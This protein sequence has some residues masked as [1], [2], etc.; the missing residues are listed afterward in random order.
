[1]KKALPYFIIIAIISL[2]SCSQKEEGLTADEARN[3]AKE[4]YIYG[5]PM[6]VNYKTMYMYAIDENSPE[7]KGKFNQISCVAR[8]FTPED[9]AVVTPNSDTPYCMFWVDLR[10]GPQV[11]TLP[12]IEPDRYYSFQLVDLYT[13]N[14]A[15]L[16]TLS[17]GNSGG[18]Y[19]VAP[20][21]WDGEVPQGISDT[22]EC[23]TDLF[24]V[25]V[26]TQLKGPEDMENVKSI[27]ENYNLESLSKFNG[28]K[29]SERIFDDQFPEW[30]EGDQFTASGFRYLDV[31]LNLAT[32]VE[33]EQGLRARFTRLGIGTEEGF[34][35][36]RFDPEIQTAIEEGVKN[37][38]SEI[39]QFIA[40]DATDP[41][42]SAKI[43]GTRE[44]LT[45]SASKN[46][47]LNEFYLL[48][49]AAAQ[50]G[51]YGNSGFEAIYPTYLAEAPGVP[52]NAAE[53]KYTITFEKDQLPPV[54]AFWS[55][56]MYDGKTQLF[57][58]N[59]LERY[60][61][62]TSNMDQFVFNNDGSLTLYVQKD[63]PG[64]ALESNWL[65]APDGPFY[66]V[67]RLYG[68]KDEAL[69][70]KWKNPPLIRAS[71]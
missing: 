14:F 71:E 51:L 69:E 63:S 26:R 23:E 60:L 54:K 44:F 70:G 13:H 22:I 11:L 48:R 35:I 46:F 57:I 65:P 62:N 38:F 55:L 6:I 68:P 16:G 39:E 45:Q 34:D 47:Q 33:A 67:M 64:D 61:L 8:L 25:V 52:Y 28:E 5:L 10:N 4:A 24:F 1:M 21:G 12:E 7:Y 43:F 36:S 42:M 41:L 30:N 19:V 20:K 27:Q 40:A 59:K 37:G 66:C 9:K 53:H 32:P 17:T 31:M 18:S 29:E 56:S 50:T 49:A 58:H 15:Y 3:I 2:G